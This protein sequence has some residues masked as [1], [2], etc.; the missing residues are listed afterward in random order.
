MDGLTAI[1]DDCLRA[2]GTYIRKEGRSP[3]RQE[4][5]ELIGQKSTNGVRQILQALQ[6]KGYVKIGPPGRARNITVIHVPPKQL[7]LL[8]AEVKPTRE[9]A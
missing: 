7:L 8:P 4:L 2:I 3:T 1:Q 9:E 6:R 5:A